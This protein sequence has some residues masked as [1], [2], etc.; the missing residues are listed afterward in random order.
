MDEAGTRRHLKDEGF[1][2][3]S[4]LPPAESVGLYLA[5]QG[6]RENGFEIVT[7]THPH[8]PGETLE[9]R[10]EFQALSG[11]GGTSLAARHRR[12]RIDTF[13]TGQPQ[14]VIALD[15]FNGSGVDHGLANKTSA[16]RLQ[17]GSQHGLLED[18]G[19]YELYAADPERVLVGKEGPRLE[20][21]VEALDEPEKVQ[22]QLGEFHQ[23][24]KRLEGELYKHRLEKES[25]TTWQR[26]LCHDERFDWD[27][28]GSA[29]AKLIPAA[30]EGKQYTGVVGGV[31]VL[32]ALESRFSDLE[33]LAGA[34]M[35]VVPRL[36]RQPYQEVIEGFETHPPTAEL[37]P[38]WADLFQ[39]TRDFGAAEHGYRLLQEMA[40]EEP[41]A[42]LKETFT[43]VY[44]ATGSIEH[45]E[46]ACRQVPLGPVE[47]QAQRLESYRKLAFEFP[48]TT[49]PRYQTLLYRRSP[50][51][52]LETTTQRYL[53]L[54]EG[55]DPKDPQP[56]AT[57]F[58]R[59]Q[60]DLQAGRMEPEDCADAIERFRGL[61]ATLAELKG[62][63]RQSVA[64]YQV[65]HEAI[66]EGRMTRGQADEKI[67]DMGVQGSLFGAVQG[68]RDVVDDE[69]IEFDIDSVTIGDVTISRFED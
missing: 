68:L 20:V 27:V 8:D 37:Q 24:C 66:L 11:G 5:I 38:L 51:E 69:L 1:L 43:S 4:G 57:V 41:S 12:Q 64:L 63:E 28:R 47:E 65:M 6:L 50:Q 25:P 26:A 23:V 61:R 32:K 39:T 7:D 44:G 55:S 36:R 19:L 16:L 62:T 53:S 31:E 21:P 14:K 67:R 18:S 46:A 40:L 34:V 30:A 22:S 60:R 15:F 2:A 33:S 58:G 17:S 54:A 52:S 29:L 59:F 35:E 42:F 45:A 49:G 3:V 56:T 10:R 48:A 9:P 13:V